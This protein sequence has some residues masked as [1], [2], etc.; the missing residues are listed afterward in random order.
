M[1]SRVQLPAPSRLKGLAGLLMARRSVREYTGERVSLL[2]VA[3]LLWSAQGISHSSGRRTVPSP[4]GVNLLTLHLV[5][6]R[7]GDLEPG[8][9]LYEPRRHALNAWGY[10]DLRND[11][12]R[13]A[14]EDQPW[15][16]ACAA[17]IVISGN[18]ERE[19]AEFAD[20]PPDGKR[21]RRYMHMEAG[22]AAQN[23]AL[24][25]VEMKLG[26][27]VV[28]GFHDEQVARCLGI[29]TEPLVMMPLGRALT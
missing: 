9:Y 29:G 4:H 8:L 16:S 11:L 20:Q 6:A 10:G 28:G 1:S 3:R 7:V 17:L 26:T 19:E 18:G 5:A 24:R 22:M 27:V 15:I 13:A 12:Y 21:G 23:I 25:A 2:E 14:L